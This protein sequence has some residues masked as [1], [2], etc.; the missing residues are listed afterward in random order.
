MHAETNPQAEQNTHRPGAKA[1]TPKPEGPITRHR[2]AHQRRGETVI[3]TMYSG[4]WEYPPLP[5]A[6]PDSTSNSESSND[7]QGR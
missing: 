7:R 4:T 1:P 3:V 6:Q 5:A 2:M